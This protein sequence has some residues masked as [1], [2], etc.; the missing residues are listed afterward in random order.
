[1][2]ATRR[3]KEDQFWEI[4]GIAPGDNRSKNVATPT[5]AITAFRP[6]DEGPDIFST[7]ERQMTD[8]KLPSENSALGNGKRDE[9]VFTY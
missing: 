7:D 3:V 1:M 6:P 9:R 5:S 8:P 4:R 2:L